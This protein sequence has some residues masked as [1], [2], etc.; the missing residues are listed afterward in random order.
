[1]RPKK[2]LQPKKVIRKFPEELVVE[3]PKQD[4]RMILDRMLS[5]EPTNS[6]IRYHKPLPPDGDDIVD[7]DTGTTQ[8]LDLVDQQQYEEELEQHLTAQQKEQQAA[9]EA[10]AKAEFDARVDE[11]IKQRTTTPAME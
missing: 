10:K 11:A 7:F 8:L 5:D 6:N 4:L 1:M 9:A 3:E 2:C